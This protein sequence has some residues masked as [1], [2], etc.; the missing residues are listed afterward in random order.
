EEPEQ[1]SISV[2]QAPVHPADLIVLTVGVVVPTLGPPELVAGQDHGSAGGE[3]QNRREV[4]HLPP[5]QPI[6]LLGVSMSL[7]AAVPAQVIMAAVGVP[8]AVGFI[9]LVVVGHQVSQGQAI[10]TGNEVQTV[11]RSP[12][13]GLI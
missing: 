10:V 11:I 7:V 1:I 9:V 4:P 6:D 12:A 13:T 3:Q 5:A 8:L 2:E